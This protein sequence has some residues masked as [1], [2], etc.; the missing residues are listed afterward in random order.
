MINNFEVIRENVRIEQVASSLLG[1]STNKGLYKYPNER[2]ASIKI[3]TNT[4]SFYDFGRGKGGDVV[5]F[6]SHILH[7]E[8]KES[9]EWFKVNYGIPIN[10]LSLSGEEVQKLEADRQRIKAEREAEKD[11]ERKAHK[12]LITK[13]ERLRGQ[14][15]ESNSIVNRFTLEVEPTEDFYKALETRTAAILELR[16]IYAELNLTID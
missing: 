16:H 13:I 3:Y 15:E 10:V 12:T 7:L 5:S 9:L 6:V 14:I 4:N 8:P 1:K 2:T 11:R